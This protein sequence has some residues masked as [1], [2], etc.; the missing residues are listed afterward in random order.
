MSA[1]AQDAPPCAVCWA[2]SV[3]VGH[4]HT[5]LRPIQCCKLALSNALTGLITATAGTLAGDVGLH[6]TEE[7]LPYP[8]RAQ[9]RLVEF[10][11]PTL[12]CL[13]G[14]LPVAT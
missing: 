2:A 4:R 12:V 10:H 13:V 3:D 9:R 7:R 11:L 8:R 6:R 14:C 5:S 1:L